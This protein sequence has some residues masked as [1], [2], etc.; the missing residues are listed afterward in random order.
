MNTQ[1]LYLSSALW[2]IVTAIGLAF[3]VLCIATNNIIISG[4][5]VVRYIH[6]LTMYV[7]V[8]GAFFWSFWRMPGRL[9]ED[10]FTHMCHHEY[11]QSMVC[12]V[13]LR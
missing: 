6:L 5:A 2:G 10:T 12:G 3:L 8:H 7:I 11:A 1:K 4:A 9:A 13:Q